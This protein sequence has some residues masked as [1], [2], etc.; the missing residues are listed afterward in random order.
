MKVAG[1]VIHCAI[2][3]KPNQSSLHDLQDKRP[4][5]FQSAFLMGKRKKT[6]SSL[7]LINMGEWYNWIG[8]VIIT[9][10]KV[11]KSCILRIINVSAF[12]EE[13]RLSSPLKPQAFIRLEPDTKDYK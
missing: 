13:W 8:Y 4:L 5:N 9:Y 6:L 3:S 1:C 2:C 11:L 7:L 10:L 12:F